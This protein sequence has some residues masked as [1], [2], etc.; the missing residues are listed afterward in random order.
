MKGFCIYLMYID[1]LDFIWTRQKKSENL[2][3][4]S[5][6]LMVRS[7]SS[8]IQTGCFLMDVLWHFLLLFLSWQVSFKWH[9]GSFY[10]SCGIFKG[11]FQRSRLHIHFRG[12]CLVLHAHFYK[13]LQNWCFFPEPELVLPEP[14]SKDC[15]TVVLF[16]LPPPTLHIKFWESSHL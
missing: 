6:P 12:S 3:S 4:Y 9:Q 8:S 10:K 13:T 5:S 1:N 2:I 7:K 16:I 15:W 11:L 14:F